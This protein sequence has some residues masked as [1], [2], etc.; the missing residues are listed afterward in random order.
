MITSKKK[1][2]EM[3]KFTLPHFLVFCS[4]LFLLRGG[5]S[6][7]MYEIGVTNPY[8][9]GFLRQNILDGKFNLHVYKR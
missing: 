4:V 3:M 7:L 8:T 1:N 6:F 2:I 9:F 5:L